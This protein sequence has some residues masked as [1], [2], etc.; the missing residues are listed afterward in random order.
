MKPTH[1][2][3][4]SKYIDSTSKLQDAIL[5]RNDDL[6]TRLLP[7]REID[8]R[9]IFDSIKDY[10]NFLKQPLTLSQFVPCGAD[11]KPLEKPI[12]HDK[13]PIETQLLH[14][15]EL[16]PCECAALSAYEARYNEAQK[17]VIFEGWE[18]LNHMV[19]QN[20]V[21]K[22]K[23]MFI[24]AHGELRIWF[25]KFEHK[26]AYLTLYIGNDPTLA[27]LASATISNPIKFK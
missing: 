14:S 18:V 5:S 20:K 4:V 19:I 16:E 26:D 12:K 9:A 1:L 7:V 2:M 11:G 21:T 13:C 25:D 10:N 27:D 23:F 3:T 15:Q 24:L 17:N 22:D 8:W 6:L